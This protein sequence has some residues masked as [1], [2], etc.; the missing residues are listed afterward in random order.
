MHSVYFLKSTTN[1]K[2]YV[3]M[4][5]KDPKQRA[6]EHNQGSND[7]TSQNGPFTLVYYESYC[8]K[9]DAAKREAFYKTGMGRRI[10]DA[11]IG[12]VSAKGGPASGGG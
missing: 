12:A 8:C 11:I 1:G 4:T 9:E 6:L 10:R 7:W 5:E 2:Y 3:G